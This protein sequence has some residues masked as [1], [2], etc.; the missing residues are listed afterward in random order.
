MA[1]LPISKKTSLVEIEARP[2]LLYVKFIGPQVGQRESPIISAEVEPYIKE[3]GKALQSFVIDMRGVTFMS[4]MGLGVCIALRHKAN[5]GG[6]KAILYGTSP[7]LLKLFT[8]MK[9][10]QLYKFAKDQAEL[11]KLL[12]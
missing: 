2:H 4:S 9:I 10:D 8:M 5:T 11:D 12:G 6:A 1:G 3:Y 7:D